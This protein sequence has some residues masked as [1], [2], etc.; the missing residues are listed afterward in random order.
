MFGSV[1]IDESISVRAGIDNLLDPEPEIVGELPGVNNN[2]GNTLPGF[3]DIL[4]RRFWI[5]A[6]FSF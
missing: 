6:S 3:Y 4:G 2:K 5:G 1:R